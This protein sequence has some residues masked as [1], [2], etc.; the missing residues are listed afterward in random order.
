MPFTGTDGPM[1]KGIAAPARHNRDWRLSPWEGACSLPKATVILFGSPD[2]IGL[3]RRGMDATRDV[4]EADTGT[5]QGPPA[6]PS[7]PLP[8]LR[9]TARLKTV[10]SRLRCES[11]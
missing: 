4:M 11:S 3:S 7:A 10:P 6:A 9:S 8:D 2:L 1:A 5:L